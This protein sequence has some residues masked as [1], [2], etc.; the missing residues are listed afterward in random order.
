MGT[1]GGFY[2]IGTNRIFKEEQPTPS[3][4]LINHAKRFERRIEKVADGI[5]SAIGYAL[6]N[7]ILIVTNQGNVIID[8][9][10]SLAATQEIKKEFEKISPQPT[11]AVIYTHGHTDHVMGTSAFMN[12]GTEVYANKRT[13]EFFDL[14]FSQIQDILGLRGRRQFGTRLPDGY[15]PCSGLGIGLKID[16]GTPILVTPTKLFD[17]SMEL[18]FGD[19]RMT[20]I[21]APGETEDQIFIWLP[22]KKVLLS[23]D[24]YYPSFPNLY[25]IRGTAPR[26]VDQWIESLDKMR[27]LG[28]EYLVPSHAE[29]IR[30]AERVNEL[31]TMYR[32]AIQYVHDAV[33]RGA[34]QGK[35]PDQLVEEIKLPPHLLKN[36][37]LLELYGKVSWSVRAIYEQYLGWFDGNA[38]NLDRLS[39]KIRAQ[40]IMD[41]SGGSKR[42]LEEGKKALETGDYQ[43]AAEVA[44]MLLA[45]SPEDVEALDIKVEALFRLGEL[46][47]SS[48]GRSYYFTQALELAGELPIRPIPLKVK[49]ANALAMPLETFFKN[50]SIRLDP[51]AS[52]E[53]TIAVGF[54]ITDAQETYMVIVRRGVAE[55]R[56]EFSQ[57]PDVVVQVQGDLWKEISLGV[58][59]PKVAMENGQIEI[60]GDLE[61][62]KEFNGLFAV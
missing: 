52:A 35:T 3:P 48:N 6:G 10:E 44:D 37:E 31:L 29:P 53:K 56:K 46:C 12:E 25:A 42:L 13:K 24:N 40:K 9:T 51:T 27:A 38:T 50:M 62:L 32:D 28:A 14:Q 30:G 36:T 49:L 47:H 41:L 26:P 4:Y 55:V 11:I 21:H 39:P 1:A 17:E 43:W 61:T 60:E 57:T 2:P 8:T 5:Y 33:L 16:R 22:D 45:V 59:D 34:N 54:A 58:V 20:L 7:C 23:G 15:V 19:V 18:T